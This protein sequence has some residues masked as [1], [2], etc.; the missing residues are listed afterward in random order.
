MSDTSA[1]PP[2]PESGPTASR[3][4]FKRAIAL[5]EGGLLLALIVLALLIGLPHPEF[6]DPRSIVTVL[7]QSAFVGIVAFGVVYLIAMVE[8]DLSV[9]ALYLMSATLAALAIESGGIDPWAAAALAIAATS[10]L[11]AL[12]GV[13]AN[14]LSVPIII[15]S[16]GT[17]SAIRGGA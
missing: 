13:L 8:I 10:A 3:K 16:L 17:L 1:T 9:G 14:L 15:V 5:E 11:G 7:R 12:N 6:F 2:R 4:L